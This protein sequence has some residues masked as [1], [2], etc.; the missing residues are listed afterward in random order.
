M[1]FYW[2]QIC[3]QIASRYCKHN[4]CFS[5]VSV[6]V[7]GPV[8]PEHTE[9]ED[10]AWMVKELSLWLPMWVNNKKTGHRSSEKRV[11][12]WHCVREAPEY[13]APCLALCQRSTQV[14]CAML[15]QAQSNLSESSQ[16]MELIRMSLE[17]RLMELE[18]DP[19]MAP[20]VA[21][22]R[23]ELDELLNT[24][25]TSISASHRHSGLAANSRNANTF[26]KAAAL[27]G[28]LEVR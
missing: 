8:E 28:K 18:P 10:W 23:A 5:I 17:K 27:T 6:A 19:E 7:W 14:L 13:Y 20:K 11:C 2:A 9:P 12:F 21:M 16:K 26:S 4:K 15:F 3:F 25:Y 22:L 24:T 1:Q